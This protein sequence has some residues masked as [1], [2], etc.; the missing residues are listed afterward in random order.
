MESDV[1]A[2][3]VPRARM[4]LE[5]LQARPGREAV[6][7]GALGAL[8]V[9]SLLVVLGLSA[10]RP[11]LAPYNVPGRPVWLGGPL[12]D[13]VPGLGRAPFVVLLVAMT[14]LYLLVVARADALRARWVL[15]AVALLHVAYAAAPPLVQ[16]DVF[17]YLMYGRLGVVHHLVP[18]L[19]VPNEVPGDVARGYMGWPHFPSP[20]GPVFTLGSYALA[21]VDLP[22]GVWLV[23]G[24]LG[25]AGL[26]CVGL[27]W[28]CARRLGAP[29]VPAAVFVG[30][31]PLLVVW[32]V[33]AAHNDLLMLALMLAGLRMALA[34]RAA[35]GAGLVVAAAA[36]KAS[37]GLVLPFMVLRGRGPVRVVAGAAAAV[38]LLGVAAVASF[39]ADGVGGYLAAL[40][41]Q[42]QLVSG[43][44]VPNDLFRVVGADGMPDAL[45]PVFSAL[46]AVGLVGLLV[47]A[48][49]GAD[50]ITCAGWATLTLLLTMTFLMPWYLVWLLPLAALG[51]SRALQHATLGL[52]CFMVLT[53][54]IVLLA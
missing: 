8:V 30:L 5:G 37:S 20:Y 41:A 49:R 3:P 16:T 36:V 33:G 51:R 45:K 2:V 15:G 25:V 52:M 27:T 12:A 54:G 39:G 40:A 50:W 21:T 35:L 10:A 22:L 9:C 11:P 46:F 28:S 18:Y 6:A 14:A 53:R 1:R 13:L 4:W 29:P 24:I 19:H 32:G 44:S 23:K 34:E 48:A 26:A 17:G 42:Q 31:N 47:W 43:H 38:A 7:L